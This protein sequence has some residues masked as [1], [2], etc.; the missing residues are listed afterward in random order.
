MPKLTHAELKSLLS[1]A[2]LTEGHFRQVK[3][4]LAEIPENPMP[5]EITPAVIQTQFFVALYK[6]V[7]EGN[8]DAAVL[9]AEIIPTANLPKGVSPDFV[10]AAMA[11]EDLVR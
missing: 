7:C 11:A 6:M 10:S 4:T 3:A 5:H 8:P 2:D 9:L 1:G